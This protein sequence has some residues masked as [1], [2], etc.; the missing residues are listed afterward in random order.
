MEPITFISPVVS[1]IENIPDL[2][3]VPPST[4]VSINV[5]SCC[6]SRSNSFSNTNSLYLPPSGFV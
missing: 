3:G 4:A 1:L 2:C 5:T 6:S